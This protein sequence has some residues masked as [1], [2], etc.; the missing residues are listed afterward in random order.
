[1]DPKKVALFPYPKVESQHNTSKSK[2]P[3]VVD[4]RVV[5]D[6]QKKALYL[7]FLRSSPAIFALN[8]VSSSG[9]RNIQRDSGVFKKLISGC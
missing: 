2:A 4:V 5:R 1:M 8:D 6:L 3:R 9:C 7:C